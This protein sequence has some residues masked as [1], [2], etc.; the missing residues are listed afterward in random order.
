M[1]KALTSAQIAAINSARKNISRL[2]RVDVFT[3]ATAGMISMDEEGNFELTSKANRALKRA[4]KAEVAE[5]IRPQVWEAVGMVAQDSEKMFRLDDVLKASGLNKADH[6]QDILEALRH[7]RDGGMLEN[8][9]LSDN[10]F[11]IYWKRTPESLPA[12]TEE[13]AGEE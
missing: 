13:A 3:L 11:Q 12:A 10:N 8:I 7:F 5:K 2:S 4:A 1:A 6:R 9:K